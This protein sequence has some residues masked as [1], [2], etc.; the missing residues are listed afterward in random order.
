M[1][2]CSSELY[3]MS[4]VQCNF[5]FWNNPDSTVFHVISF[6]SQHFVCNQNIAG[7][8]SVGR[9]FSQVNLISRPMSGAVRRRNE[10]QQWKPYQTSSIKRVH[11]NVQS[12]Y[13]AD[14]IFQQIILMESTSR[15][16]I[17]SR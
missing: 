5:C 12:S 17:Q 13:K 16:V 11:C 6:I 7:T 1:F 3:F 8:H 15:D 10:Q 4:C 14:I 9:A 2:E